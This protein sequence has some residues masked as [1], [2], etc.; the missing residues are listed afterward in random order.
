M[1]AEFYG[2][3]AL[4]FNIT[5]DPGFLYLN[6]CYQEA[7]AALTYGIEARKGFISLIGDA[8]TGKT[9]LLRR[10]LDSVD[11]GTRTVLLLNPSVSFDEILEHILTELG[12]PTD[13]GRKLAL[14]QRL[15]EFLI[16]HTRSGGNVALL[17]DE[18]QD[19][20][21]GVL[22]QLRLLSNLETARE[23]ILQIV[24]AGQP[25]LETTLSDPALRQLRQRVALRVRLRP[26]TSAEVAAYVK[27]RLEHVGATDTGLFTAEALERVAFYSAGIPRVV[28]VLC[29]AALVSGFAAERR[30]ITAAT[31][32]E[33]WH[34]YASGAQ[35]AGG[36]IPRATMREV[37]EPAPVAESSADAPAAEAAPSE[38]SEPPPPPPPIAPEMPTPVRATRAPEAR[39]RRRFLSLPTAAA[40]IVLVAIGIAAVSLRERGME[41]FAPLL[42]RITE[43]NRV[44]SSGAA[45]VVQV[46]EAQAAARPLDQGAPRDGI[47]SATEAAEVIEEFRS[48][49]EARDV[50]RLLGLFASD[51]SENGQRGHAAIEAAYRR[52]LPTLAE[53][54]YTLDALNV[55][56]Q[57]P[58][59]QVRAPFVIAYR[60]P[61]GGS[62]IIRGE[63]EW[64][65]ER[66]GGRPLI[67]ALNYRLEPEAKL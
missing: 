18:A 50:R 25:E 44:T 45:P 63:A 8:G 54:R 51:A 26:L 29:D 65:L 3:R 52:S 42:A 17:I 9:T 62:G 24:L 59:A 38:P 39:A 56:T 58:T 6:D 30:S 33:A 23:K 37:E 2:F 15:N 40:A 13:G 27:S 66:R 46:A 28:N 7:I 5:P 41:V 36:F 21:A 43:G 19:L 34:D 31:V 64:Q 60:Q 53:V 47:V 67:T 48:A 14:L 32:D 49:Y 4:P 1:Y 61:S 12:V 57:G 35:L 55:Q 22:E 16:E 10:V 11:P 20:D